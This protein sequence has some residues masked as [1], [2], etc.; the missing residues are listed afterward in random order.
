MLIIKDTIKIKDRENFV[1]F[2]VRLMCV[3]Y[4]I[5][6]SRGGRML[7]VYYMLY[8]IE[9]ETHKRFIKDNRASNMNSLY[10]LRGEL[11]K[12][13]VLVKGRY[14]N[15]Y[16]LSEHFNSKIEEKVGFL[17]SVENELRENSK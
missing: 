1:E 3:L 17:I 15:E 7:V 8:G 5:N 12:F 10:N 4:N 16:S 2:F 11:K 14:E 13:N 6:L 9:E